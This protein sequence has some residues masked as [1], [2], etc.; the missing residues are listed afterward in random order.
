[1]SH[2]CLRALPGTTLLEVVAALAIL[3]LA[4]TSFLELA[5]QQRQ[6]TRALHERDARMREAA[7]I[8]A[9]T[10]AWPAGELRGRVGITLVKGQRVEIA[11]IAPSLY[12]IAVLDGATPSAI[13]RTSRYAP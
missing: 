2:D 10:V 13:L 9:R 7:N 11:V 4:G 6:A 3:A 12:S 8:L 5:V 1:V